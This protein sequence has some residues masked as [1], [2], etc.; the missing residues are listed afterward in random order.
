MKYKL[1]AI[2]LLFSF[3]IFA[4]DQ[5]AVLQSKLDIFNSK[6]QQTEKGERLR[7]MDSLATTI[8]FERVFNNSKFK[9]DSI[10]TQ[11][12]KYAISLDSLN[13]AAEHVA[14][15]VWY[16]SYF[17]KKPKASVLLYNT[18]KNDFKNIENNN[19]LSRLYLYLGDSFFEVEGIDKSLEYYIKAKESSTK[20]GNDTFLGL[21]NLNKGQLESIK[22]QFS[23]AS[24]SYK[25]AI[26]LF[27]KVENTSYI[28]N[29]KNSLANLYSKNAFYEEAI[30]ERN[31]AIEIANNFGESGLLV[32]IYMSAAE[33]YKQIG[34][35]V[36]QIGYLKAAINVFNNN[37]KLENYSYL[38]TELLADLSNAYVD[39]DSLNLAEQK[40]KELEAIYFKETSKQ[41]KPYYVNARKTLAYAKGHYKESLKYCK[42]YIEIQKENKNIDGLMKGEKSLSLTYKA[43]GEST[44]SNIHLINFYRIKD[45]VS[46]IQNVKS[47]AYYQT[48]YET[49]K[50]DLKIE[51]QRASIGLLNLKNKN[52]NQLLIFGALGL[53]VLFGGIVFYRSFLSAKR[54]QLRQQLFSQELIKTQ[55]KERTRIAKDLHDGVGQQITLIKM[56]AQN[57]NQIEL[58]SLAHNALEEVRSISR[59]LY[60]VTLAKLG[61]TDS[62]EQLLLE[63]DEETDLFV[64]VEIDDVNERFNEIE[65]LNLYRFIQESVNNVLKH[66]NAKT[67]IVNILKKSDSIKI[68]IKDNGE[69]FEVTDKVNQ[70]SLG[71]KTMAER[72]SMLKGS[73]TIKSKRTE[74]TSI[75]VKIPV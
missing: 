70:N 16:N 39:S 65:S 66:A 33:N 27:I 57:T 47:L 75:L 42:E 14:N 4:Q 51:N 58:S 64:S 49:E 36:K 32:G 74:G 11:T 50:R 6:I 62:I 18:Y 48:L 30:E 8:Y 19:T 25:T 41:S 73:F 17:L 37:S 12:I 61:L 24:I 9:Y 53:L 43:L 52:K 45:S 29:T 72:I 13:K 68:L 71:L 26:D 5:D 46:S 28:I 44:N 7:W 56:R 38:K 2:T 40:F 31:E 55:E 1:L 21:A 54:R 35:H 67:L 20:S 3:H 34:N 63:L 60:P 69:G 10:T 22:G 15:L 59:D 23:E